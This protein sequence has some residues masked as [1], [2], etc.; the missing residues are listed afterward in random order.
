M[1]RIDTSALSALLRTQLLSKAQQSSAKDSGLPNTAASSAG[2]QDVA[3]QSSKKPTSE[4]KITAQLVLEPKWVQRLQGVSSDDP[5]RKRKAFRIFLESVL[6]K[7]LG[8]AFQSD[9]QFSQVVEQVLQQIES[10][11]ELNENSLLVGEI[12]LDQLG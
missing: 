7:E 8:S 3:T 5:Q 11:V 12:L 2:G 1:T 9:I 4:L 10:D 6:E